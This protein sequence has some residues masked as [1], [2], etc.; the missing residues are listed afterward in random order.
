L[1]DKK[2]KKQNK[3]QAVFITN[4]RM[5]L[6][7]YLK[8]G[9]EHHKIIVDNL[10]MPREVAL[11]LEILKILFHSLQEVFENSNRKLWLNGKRTISTFS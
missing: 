3:K 8:G 9:C 4:H 10:A 2:V 1:A 11:F 6:F 7:F 5:F